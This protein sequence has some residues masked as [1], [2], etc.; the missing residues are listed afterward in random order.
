[1][2]AITYRA[3]G[4]ASEVLRVE[5]LP[6]PSPAVGEVLIDVAFSGVNPSDVKTRTRGQPGLQGFPW[7]YIT[8]HSD[9]SGVICAVFRKALREP[10]KA[11]SAVPA[12]PRH[13]RLRSLR[14]KRSLC[15]MG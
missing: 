6:S 13:N 12:G 3:F 2:K 10:Q 1:M 5:D 14:S 11:N 4:A 8:P 7:D 9:G 15:R